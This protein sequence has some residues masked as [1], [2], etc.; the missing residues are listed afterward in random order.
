MPPINKQFEREP[1]YS[2]VSNRAERRSKR[3]KVKKPKTAKGFG[4]LVKAQKV[5]IEVA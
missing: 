1:D 5:L 4:E 3:S 2:Q